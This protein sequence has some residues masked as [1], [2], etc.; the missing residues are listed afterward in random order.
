MTYELLDGIADNVNPVL[1]AFTLLWA[2][3]VR[4]R[5][6]LGALQSNVATLVAVAVVYAFRAVDIKLKLWPSM[7]LDYSTHTGVHV[8]IVVSLWFIDKRAGLIGIGVALA[9]AALMIYQRYHTAADILSTAVVIAASSI[10]V[11][12]VFRWAARQNAI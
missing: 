12:L 8:A 3:I 10:A 9:Y 1:G 11:W 4:K 2:W 6:R 5:S 7:G